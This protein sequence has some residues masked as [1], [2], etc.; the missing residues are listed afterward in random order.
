MKNQ[1]IA[2]IAS[3]MVVVVF[4]SHI[5][6]EN[7]H[8]YEKSLKKAK[9]YKSKIP[10]KIIQK[11]PLPKGY[12]EGLFID[13][14]N[15]WINNGRGGN[16][17]VV[18]LDSGDIISQI[19]PV[20]DFT[21]GIT[22]YSGGKY[23]VTDWNTKKLYLVKIE[24]GRMVPESEISLSPSRPA[25]VIWNGR[26]LYVITWTRGFGTKYHL[27]KMDAAGK[28]LD[29]IR[30]AE[31]PEP[32]QLAWDGKN[33]W[34][35]SWFHRRVYK[36]NPETFEIKGYFSSRIKRTSGIVWDGK[37]FWLTGTTSDLYQMEV[38]TQ[39]E[40]EAR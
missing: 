21:E 40:E 7:A 35:S 17:W 5:F 18:S 6:S 14:N 8:A 3:F 2:I 37:Y 1:Q 23:W 28:I 25:G 32:T 36:I 9:N 19:E 12:H 11:I 31:I 22:A 30:I 16:T 13:G 24:E 33:L 34:I 15:V 27:L 10:A 20:A 29:K 26:H 4:G 39:K 38:M